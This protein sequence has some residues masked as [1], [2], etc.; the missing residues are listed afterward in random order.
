M[1]VLYGTF[2]LISIFIE[3]YILIHVS[4]SVCEK[5]YNKLK[6]TALILILSVVYTAIISWS[7]T[8]V[9]VPFLPIV[10][11][12]A[13]SFCMSAVVSKGSHLLRA[14]S[15]MAVCFFLHTFDY[16][17]TYGYMLVTENLIANKPGDYGHLAFLIVS[18]AVKLIL[19]CAIGRIFFNF[20]KLEKKYTLLLLIVSLGS[21]IMMSTFSGIIIGGSVIATQMV[22]LFFVLFTALSLFA[23]VFAVTVKTK[24]EKEKRESELMEMTNSMM[25]KNFLEMET[26]HNALRQQIHDFRNHILALRGMLENDGEATAYIEELLQ[27]SYALSRYSN[28]GNKVIDS[29]INCKKAEAKINGIDMDFNVRLSSTLHMSPIDICAVLANQIDNALEAC[30]KLEN[31]KDKRI[32]VE[33]WQKEAFV[34]FKVINACRE[35]PF[36]RKRELVSTKNDPSGLHG[37]GVKNIIKTA[38]SYGGAVK[39]D[40]VDGKFI[41]VVMMPN[42]KRSKGEI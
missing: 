14:S 12:I 13:V 8:V 10:I 27:A 6:N 21:Y 2:N 15:L 30:V 32:S 34:F 42:N 4:S 18:E 5:R 41:S 36:N 40:Y 28:C 3:G 20:R 22:A 31:K 7:A 19:F 26:S 38:E 25:Q 29:I 17:I 35:N 24:Y 9:T 1:D 23:T 11:A 16:L 33:I 39:N 37:Y